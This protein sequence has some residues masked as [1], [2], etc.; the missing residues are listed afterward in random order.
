MNSYH[1]EDSENTK[2]DIERLAEVEIRLAH[3]Q[4][5]KFRYTTTYFGYPEVPENNDLSTLGVSELATLHLNNAGGPWVH[6]SAQMHTKEFEREALAFVADLYEVGDDYWGYTTSGDTEGRE[7]NTLS[8]F[9][10]GKYSIPG[11]D[12]GNYFCRL[13]AVILLSCC[14]LLT[15]KT[16]SV[17]QVVVS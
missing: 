9:L 15:S 16:C 11:R 10:A 2:G 5:E 1:T 7:G 3:F 14:R 17:S 12:K 13:T 8:Q 4:A 6:G